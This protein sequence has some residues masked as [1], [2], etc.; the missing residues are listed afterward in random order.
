MQALVEASEGSDEDLAVFRSCY[1][2]LLFAVPNRGLDNSSLI[3]MVKG[4]PNEDLVRN[5]SGTSRFLRLLHQRFNKCF[6]LDDSKIICVYETEKT[7]T[8][9]VSFRLSLLV[10]KGHH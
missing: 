8:V 7:P 4:Q 10:Y 1:A 5:L 3:S 6:T 2:V 9:E